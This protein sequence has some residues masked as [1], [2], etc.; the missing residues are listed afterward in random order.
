M[1]ANFVFTYNLSMSWVPEF[2]TGA[3]QWPAVFGRIR[4]GFMIA[5]FTLIGFMTLRQAYICGAVLLPLALFIWHLT[6]QLQLK[7]RAVFKAPSLTSASDKDKEINKL[8]QMKK[9]DNM[10]QFEQFKAI[11]KAY[12]PP[13]MGI[14]YPSYSERSRKAKERKKRAKRKRSKSR[15]RDQSDNDDNRLSL[16]G[17]GDDNDNNEDVQD[18]YDRYQ[19]V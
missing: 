1:F 16:G 13:I 4:F 17:A 19:N 10:R 7:F 11:D 6:G 5:L 2:E 18:E 9:I 3:K 15:E 12:L 8:M 14:N